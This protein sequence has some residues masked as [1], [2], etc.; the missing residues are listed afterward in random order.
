MSDVMV[1]TSLFFYTVYDI[2]TQILEYYML[3]NRTD[4]IF[5]LGLSTVLLCHIVTCLHNVGP[6]KAFCFLA[7]LQLSFSNTSSCLLVI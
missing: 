1:A 3:S 6:T 7:Y 4:S 2:F 5:K